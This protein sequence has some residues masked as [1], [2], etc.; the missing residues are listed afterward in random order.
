MERGI[1]HGDAKPIR[2]SRSGRDG[3]NLK[4]EP[5]CESPRRMGQGEGASPMAWNAIR[6]VI[7]TPTTIAMRGTLYDTH[8]SRGDMGYGLGW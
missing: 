3:G 8:N 1:C 5:D 2:V 6:V 4:S 7:L